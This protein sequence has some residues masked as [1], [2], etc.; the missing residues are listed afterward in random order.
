LMAS[1]LPPE[2]VF[3]NRDGQDAEN[4]RS[5]LRFCRRAVDSI[6]RGVVWKWYGHFC[7]CV[8]RAG[9]PCPQNHLGR[10]HGRREEELGRLAV[11]DEYRL[12]AG[13]GVRASL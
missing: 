10:G 6:Q 12:A 13:K 5:R 9:M 2:K 11:R 1:R 7:P 3:C 8:G 4:V